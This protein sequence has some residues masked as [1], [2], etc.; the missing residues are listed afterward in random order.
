MNRMNGMTSILKKR[1]TIA[2]RVAKATALIVTVCA[3]AIG[4]SKPQVHLDAEGLA[5]RPI[6]ELTGKTITRDYAS[7][8]S[9]LAAVLDSGQADRLGE[10][11]IGFAKDNFT[12]RVADQNQTGVHVR[13][14]DNGHQLKAVF[15][16][17]DGTSMQLVDRA[18]LEIQTFDGNKL[19][20]TESAVHQYMV[21]MTPG[22][23]RWY[24]RDLEEMP[25]SSPQG[26]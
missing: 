24:V 3:F 11:F 6:E 25:A 16:A 9:D 4:Q 8:W 5:P 18:Q 22:A 23:D 21:L 1:A 19:L 20:D 10:Y 17:T 12:H 26:L 15:Y 2:I 13:I 7:A 14:T